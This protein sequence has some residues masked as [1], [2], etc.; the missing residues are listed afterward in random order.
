[1]ANDEVLAKKVMTPIAEEDAH[2]DDSR[3]TRD[4]SSMLH[5]AEEAQSQ[6]FTDSIMQLA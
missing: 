1:M 6:S 5:G 3:E 2:V 4:D